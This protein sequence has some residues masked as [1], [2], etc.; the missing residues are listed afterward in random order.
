[1]D[2]G[3]HGAHENFWAINPEE[4]PKN[5]FFSGEDEAG[6]KSISFR[7][8]ARGFFGR[9]GTL[10]NVFGNKWMWKEEH[11]DIVFWMCVALTDEYVQMHPLR[12]GD[13]SHQRRFKN[14]CIQLMMMFLRNERA[15]KSAFAGYFDL[16]LRNFEFK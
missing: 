1:M 2:K 11:Y 4:K 5:G 7:R 10:G 3:Y 15:C 6:N 12:N 13:T 14:L 16:Q 8:I 9:I